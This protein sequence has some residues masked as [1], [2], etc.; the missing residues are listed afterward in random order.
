V[1]HGG[2]LYLGGW[3]VEVPAQDSMVVVARWTPARLEP[4]CFSTGGPLIGS[5]GLWSLHSWNGLLIAGAQGLSDVAGFHLVGAFDGAAWRSLDFGSVDLDESHAGVYALTTWQNKLVAG[6]YFRMAG[7][8][9]SSDVAVYDGAGWQ[10]LGSGIGNDEGDPP[11]W[12]YPQGA[13][14]AMAEF[15]G[16]LYFA[17]GFQK[18]GSKPSWNIARWDP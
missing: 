3:P 2:G 17:G 1:I 8:P 14:T 10:S 13:V 5:W 18:A 12:S 4:L 16:S 6:G 11:S 15:N 9:S 7:E